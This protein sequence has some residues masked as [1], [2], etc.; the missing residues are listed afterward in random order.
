[1]TLLCHGLSESKLFT[2]L[3]RFRLSLSTTPRWQSEGL[4]VQ[5]TNPTRCIQSISWLVEVEGTYYASAINLQQPGIAWLIDNALPIGE[6]TLA[7]S[8][9]PLPSLSQHLS[10]FVPSSLGTL[11]RHSLTGHSVPPS[12]VTPSLSS[13]SLSLS[14]FTHSLST[15]SLP[16]LTFTP[17]PD[18]H[19]LSH[20]YLLFP[21]L[22]HP[23]SC[24]SLTLL[25]G[26]LSSHSCMGWMP[27]W[28][29]FHWKEVTGFGLR[30]YRLWCVNGISM[31]LLHQ[32]W[33]DR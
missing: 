4:L 11:S 25:P 17:S 26:T 29:E 30:A 7:K 6:R 27:Q 22:T 14:P 31:T 18:T 33:P 32:S 21:S 15:H 24:H 1:M 8:C 9:K 2:A 13:L 12:P 10:Q 23:L 20:H 5:T 16:L 28:L 19:S 3:I